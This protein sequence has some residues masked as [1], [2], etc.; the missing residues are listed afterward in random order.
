M[1]AKESPDITFE[2]NSSNPDAESRPLHFEI[3]SPKKQSV[4]FIDGEHKHFTYI[5]AGMNE[6][7]MAVAITID[8]L[9]I[10]KLWRV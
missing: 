7:W 2:L 8:K 6:Q 5:P 9:R 1:K 4:L 3:N 10:L